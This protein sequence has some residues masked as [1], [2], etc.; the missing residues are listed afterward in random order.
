MLSIFQAERLLNDLCV[1]L[2]FCLPPDERARL[3]STPPDTVSAFTAAVFVAEGLDPTTADRTLYG[4]V[5]AM[6]AEAFHR[7]EAGHRA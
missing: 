5:K 6:V 1:R 4:Q 7:S 3:K 2:G